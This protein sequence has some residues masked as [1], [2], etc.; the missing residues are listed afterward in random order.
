MLHIKFFIV[1]IALFILLLVTIAA[2]QELTRRR[3]ASESGAKQDDLANR[4]H[5]AIMQPLTPIM[6]ELRWQKSPAEIVSMEATCNAASLAIGTCM[7]HTRPGVQEH[8]LAA[9]FQFQ[10]QLAGAQGLAYPTVVASG[11]NTCVLHY[12]RNDNVAEAGD[13][14]LLDGGCELWGY[15]SDVTRTWPVSGRF[16]KAQ[17]DVYEVVLQ[18][19][20]ECIAACKVGATVRDIHEHSLAVLTEGLRALGVLTAR[21]GGGGLVQHAY[22]HLVGHWLGLDTH[23][24]MSVTRGR[25]LKEGVV[26][27]I[28]PGL[29]LQ[30]G[31]GLD[32]PPELHGIGVRIEDDVLVTAEGPRVLSSSVP[33]A[34]G[35]VED[36]VG[37]ARANLRHTL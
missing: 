23:D 12:A 3:K 24:C 27:T 8:H 11:A 9:L 35:E 29:Y 2:A 16:S 26:L 18:A 32:V 30:P 6:H 22:P 7:A 25:Q 14:V 19:H 20:A 17:R 36:A 4:G 21:G 15:A 34:V 1:F 5:D 13:L 28:E 31:R 37:S 10:T 33:V